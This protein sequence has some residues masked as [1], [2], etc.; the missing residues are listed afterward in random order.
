M[1]LIDVNAPFEGVLF[2]VSEDRQAH[3][4][5][6][7]VGLSNGLAWTQDGKTMYYIDSLKRTVDVMSLNPASGEICERC[8]AYMLLVVMWGVGE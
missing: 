2:H 7:Q 8:Y 3:V 4:Q 5:Q 1:G 6:T